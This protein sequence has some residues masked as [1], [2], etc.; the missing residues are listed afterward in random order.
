MGYISNCLIVVLLMSIQNP[1]Q[2][3]FVRHCM[4]AAD[5]NQKKEE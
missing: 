5:Y 4:Q 2:A 3:V 1:V